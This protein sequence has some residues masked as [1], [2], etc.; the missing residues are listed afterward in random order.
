LK[1]AKCKISSY[2]IDFLTF[3]I[4]TSYFII[5]KGGTM[6]RRTILLLLFIPVI[7]FS[8]E[9]IINSPTATGLGMGGYAFSVRLEPEGGIIFHVASSP[10]E[11]FAF[12]LSYGGTGIIGCSAP[13]WYPIKEKGPGVQ[14]KLQLVD[15]P[16]LSLGFDSQG[17]GRYDTVNDVYEI[18]SKGIYTVLGKDLF[19]R[20]YAM[21]GANYSLEQSK[22]FD[23]F[24][25]AEL[26]LSP[27]IK[28]LTDYSL[29]HGDKK[30]WLDVGI[31]FSFEEMA[32][33]EF[34]FLNLLG[35][36]VTRIAKMAYTSSF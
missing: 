30:G 34:D 9:Y 31:Q 24:A 28:I 13:D 2:K 3:I 27:E 19:E 7:G 33:F 32:S 5:Q 29:G 15:E 17:Y 20:G 35:D 4:H 8:G 12:G 10:I 26:Y 11:R 16:G 14:I 1:N 36:D 18:K 6:A 25:G 23:S 22:D 21:V